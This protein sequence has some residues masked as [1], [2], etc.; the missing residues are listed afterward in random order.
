MEKVC[1]EEPHYHCP[2]SQPLI[3]INPQPSAGLEVALSTQQVYVQPDMRKNPTH[4]QVIAED[5]YNTL[6][7]NFSLPATS[8]DSDPAYSHLNLHA[9]TS[10]H[11]PETTDPVCDGV[12]STLKL[13]HRYKQPASPANMAAY[14]N[15]VA[16]DVVPKTSHQ[17]TPHT[18]SHDTPVPYV[19]VRLVTY[20]EKQEPRR[21][22]KGF[23]SNTR[24]LPLFD[25]PTYATH[26]PS[27]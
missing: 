27:Y 21:R 9:V 10:T 25:D 20:N 5:T 17:C 2:T 11:I 7:T 1:T 24:N 12:P 22:Q 18:V 26:F 16:S 19:N 23:K 3:R 6:T 13:E 15:V 14:Y 4:Q 8:V